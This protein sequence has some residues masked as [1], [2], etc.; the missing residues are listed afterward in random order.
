MPDTFDVAVIGAGPAG[1]AAAIWASERNFSVVVLD[2]RPLPIDKACGEGLMPSGVLHLQKLGI[3]LSH[4]DASPITGICYVQEDGTRAIGKLPAPGGLGVRRLALSHALA[5][6]AVLAGVTLR[7]AEVCGFGDGRVQLTDGSIGASFVIAA[8]GLHSPTRHRLKLGDAAQGPR[9]FGLRRH[10]RRAPWSS[11]VEVH[12]ADG[13]EAYVTPVGTERIG[14]A[15]LFE[16]DRFAHV[17]FDT[18]LLRFPALAEKIGDAP[19]DSSARGLGPLRQSAQQITG[20]DFALLGDAAGYLDAITGEGI[21][22]A[23]DAAEHLAAALPATPRSLR[24]YTRAFH[25]AYRRY[26]FSAGS[27]LALARRPRLRRWAIA[28]LARVPFLFT[29]ILRL[30][31]QPGEKSP[32]T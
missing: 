29:L 19:F 22:L 26:A 25:R 18:F 6:R 16:A 28:L 30:L 14:V 12:F 9:R 2:K 24:L 32:K 5:D 13:V 11:Y 7:R 21:S 31:M 3:T 20:V 17:G 10:Y 27:V 15:F 8:D 1:L 23:F 4:Q